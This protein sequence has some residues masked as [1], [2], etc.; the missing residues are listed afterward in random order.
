MDVMDST[1]DECAAITSE[2][3]Q[4]VSPIQALTSNL[5]SPMLSVSV[6]TYAAFMNSFQVSELR[7]KTDFVGVDVINIQEAV[8][9]LVSYLYCL[10]IKKL[11]FIIL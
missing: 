1:L 3:Q 9:T 8:Q 10:L 11:I 6:V 4:D 7:K 2:T 5:G